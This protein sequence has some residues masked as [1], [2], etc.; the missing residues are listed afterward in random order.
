MLME[1]LALFLD[2]THGFHYIRGDYRLEVW[3][4]AREEL[5][6]VI[7]SIGNYRYIISSGNLIYEVA[8][9]PRAYRYVMRVFFNMDGT[10]INYKFMK[11]GL[12]TPC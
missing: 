1:R 12:R 11:Q 4:S 3:L 5:P 7:S 2:R 8:D 6:V 9:A 10:S